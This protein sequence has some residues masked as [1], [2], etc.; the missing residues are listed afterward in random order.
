M[1]RDSPKRHSRGARP[2]FKKKVLTAPEEEQLKASCSPTS[3]LFIDIS[4]MNEGATLWSRGEG[5]RLRYSL[6]RNEHQIRI[7]SHLGY[8]TLFT[9]GGAIAP[10]NYLSPSLCPF[11]WD[12]PTLDFKVLNRLS[13]PL[14]LTEVVFDIEESRPDMTPL[15][16]I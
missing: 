8:L 14:F 15:L 7:E 10:L 11:N 5:T 1:Q 9:A 6:D 3:D 2:N 12:F 13:E 4:V 16:A